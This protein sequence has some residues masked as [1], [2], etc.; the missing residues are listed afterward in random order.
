MVVVGLDEIGTLVAANVLKHPELEL[1]GVV[2]PSL[3]GRRLPSLIPGA[4]DLEIEAA[5]QRLY[6]EA[7]GGAALISAGPSLDDVADEIEQAVRAGLHVVSGCEELSN[8]WFVDP[9]L[10]DDLDALAQ[11]R[12]VAILGTGAN[13][14]FVMDR[15]VVTLGGVV[16]EIRHVEVV[17][18]VDARDKPRLWKTIG[19]GLS[20][21]EFESRADAGVLGHVG[22]GESCAL[23][24]DGLALAVDEV[25]EEIDPILAERPVE[26]GALRIPAGGVVGVRQV[27][28]ASDEGREVV[29]LTLEIG[30]GLADPGDRI[31]IQGDPKVELEI[32][33]GIEGDRATA[34]AIVNA[35]PRVAAADAGIIEV[36]DLPAGR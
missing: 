9:E 12:G 26:V 35:V 36:L 27:A 2:D 19:A 6:L 21:A 10:S 31:R 34:W 18:R 4:P 15:L 14:G 8:P 30:V 11:E 1:V 5:A 29:R 3:A 13:P 23:V 7:K 33:G 16:G 25:E 22:L 24:V 32:P 17:R 20:T 28:H